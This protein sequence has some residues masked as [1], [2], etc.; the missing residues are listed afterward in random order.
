MAQA[1]LAI[2][3]PKKDQIFLNKS[4]NGKD[5][6]DQD[7]SDLETPLETDLGEREEDSDSLEDESSVDFEGSENDEES[8]E[9]YDDVDEE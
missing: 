4:N 5:M 7:F 3:K 2:E 9:L 6:N 1:P 8:D